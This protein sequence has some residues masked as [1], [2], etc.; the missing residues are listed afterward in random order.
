VSSSA[1][2]ASCAAARKLRK[3][4][5][6]LATLSELQIMQS[7]IGPNIRFLCAEQGSIASV[8]RDLQINQQQFSKY[9]SGRS[10]PSAANLR[11]IAKHFNI[12]DADLEQAHSDFVTWYRNRMARK[13]RPQRRD[14][15]ADAFPGDGKAIRAFL[16]AYQVYYRSPA[17][18]G[19]IVVASAFL[20]EAAGTVY[21]RTME[22]PFGQKGSRRQWTRGNGKATYLSDRLFIVDHERGASGSLT[23]TI[24]TPPH[25]YRN[26]LIFGEM[27][28][29]A[30][31]PRRQPTASRTVWKRVP[32]TWSARDL[33][34]ACGSVSDRSLSVP[35]AARRY[36]LEQGSAIPPI[37]E[38]Q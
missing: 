15:L 26:E 9:L 13:E 35:P 1:D 4:E 23:T 8:C 21:S 33:L 25:R 10:H 22:S 36:L 5:R 32:A 34:K 37:N 27:L 12:E 19:K 3:L 2:D 6:L 31:Y 28:F 16:G 30:S 29:L 38:E 14:P 11:K 7:D 24:L 18:P 17:A 20:D